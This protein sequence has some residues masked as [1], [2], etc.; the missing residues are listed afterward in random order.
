M[1]TQTP[2]GNRYFMTLIDDYSRYTHLYLLKNKS[3][4]ACKIKEFVKFTQTQFKATLKI[5]RSDRGGEYMGQELREFLT[6]EG[7][8]VQL[9]APYTPQQNGCAERKNRYLVEMTRSLLTDSSLPNK[10]WGEAVTTANYLQNMLPTAGGNQTPYER[11]T[12]KLPNLSC[13]K[14]FG[15]TA[16]ASV[17]AERRQKLDDK[18]KKLVFV[19]YESGTKGYRLLDTQTDKICVS[20]DVIFVEG[21]PHVNTCTQQTVNV[22]ESSPEAESEIMLN[23]IPEIIEPTAPPQQL[24]ESEIRRSTR[25]TKGRPPERLIETINKVTTE[26]LE[27]SSFHEATSCSE[28]QHWS[29]AMDEEMEC[30]RRNNTWTLTQ[31]PDG[32]TAIGS[33]WVYKLKTDDKGTISRYKARL[34]AQGYSQK[35]G[36]DFDEVFAPVARPETFRTLLAIAGHKQMR[37]KHYDI[38]SAYL[39]GELTH[40]VYLKQPDGYHEGESNLVCKLNKSLYGL[41][42]GAIEW[43]RKLHD[44]LTKGGFK[45][46]VNDPCLY[47]KQEGSD[48]MY[49]SIHVDDLIAATTADSFFDTFEKQMSEVLVMKDLGKLQY[50]LGLQFERDDDGIFLLHQK[51]YIERKLREFN[52]YDSRPS[53][54]PVDPGYQKREE[55]HQIMRNKEVYRRA[56]GSLLYLATNSRPDISV[57]TSILARQVSNPSE[58][59]WT[60]VK[61]IF[62][63]LSHTKDKKLKL[64]NISQQDNKQLMSYADADWGGDATERKS[65]SGYIFKYLGAPIAW[66][67]RKQ[68]LVAL[69]TTEA[70]YIALSEAAQEAV[71]LRRLLTD[72]NEQITG[73]TVIFEDNQSCIKLLQNERSSHRTK[74][75]ATKYHFVRDLF[76]SGEIEVKYCPS[77]TM[78]ADML[79]KP[80]GAEKLRQFT[81]DIGLV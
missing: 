24:P 81:R 14:R 8:G 17:P 2:G 20:R 12:G 23:N 28:A 58:A 45:R 60:E 73:P 56:I 21:D 66:T 31:L 59:D 4:A 9:T 13:L 68:T 75:I 52:L 26:R 3:E 11:W 70:E 79:T 40:E 16:F 50:Y 69:S 65:N 37:V 53:N 63:Y 39:N 80:L 36:E 61:R 48:W 78:T 74:H 55:V 49:I 35:Y 57:S 10:Y 7:I 30:L 27:P 5:I 51:N 54:V 76:K 29:K 72:F 47:S 33:K 46:S 1:Q 44:I 34:V 25:Q 42:Q 77:E 62:R 43:N 6:N 19:G 22:D 41:K 38:Q 67:S 15:C 64:G 18:A 71:C 32:K